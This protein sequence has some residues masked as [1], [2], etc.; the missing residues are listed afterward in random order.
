MQRNLLASL[1]ITLMVIPIIIFGFISYQ[2]FYKS[3][4]KIVNQKDIQNYSPLPSET[5][6]LRVNASLEPDVANIEI[7]GEV[8]SDFPQPVGFK[9]S[10]I[11]IVEKFGGDGII[12]PDGS[13]I[14]ERFSIYITS[15]TQIFDEEKKLVDLNYTKKGDKVSI[16]ATPAEG[17]YEAIEVFKNE[18]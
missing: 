15:D 7:T 12:A 10:K 16:I 2:N 11:I 17:G 3:Q 4:Y 8:V 13:L 1:I 6:P 9:N 14:K 5:K 18:I